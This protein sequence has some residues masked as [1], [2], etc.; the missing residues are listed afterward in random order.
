MFDVFDIF[1]TLVRHYSIRLEKLN[2]SA[3]L[4]VCP[5][6]ICPP[7]DR[8]HSAPSGAEAETRVNAAS[9]SSEITAELASDG[10]YT[11]QNLSF[12]VSQLLKI[13]SAFSLPVFS[14]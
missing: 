8:K 7:T 12:S 9:A 1:Y 10:G 3:H 4:A 5:G 2:Q 11:C 13:S 6:D 14:K